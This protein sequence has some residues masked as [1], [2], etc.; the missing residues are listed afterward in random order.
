MKMFI[1]MHFNHPF[2]LITHYS[3]LQRKINVLNYLIIF[4]ITHYNTTVG[5]SLVITIRFTYINKD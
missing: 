3:L 2:Q 4:L 1:A 5:F